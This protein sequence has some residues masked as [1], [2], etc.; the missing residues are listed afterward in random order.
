MFFGE[1]LPPRFWQ[2]VPEDFG[3]ADL[4]IVMGTSLVVNPFA[5]L[6]GERAVLTSQ[7]WGARRM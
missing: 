2:R 4:L 7:A 6:I 3:E 5:S 1:N